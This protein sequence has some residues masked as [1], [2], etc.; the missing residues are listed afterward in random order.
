MCDGG[1]TEQTARIDLDPNDRRPA[2][3][4][5]KDDGSVRWPQTD[6]IW[7]DR[8]TGALGVIVRD[9][10][11]VTH[12]GWYPIDGLVESADF[13][14]LFGDGVPQDVRGCGQWMSSGDV[15]NEYRFIWKLTTMTERMRM[16]A[17]ANGYEVKDRGGLSHKVKAA[18]RTAQAVNE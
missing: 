13:E 1:E 17:R 8:T 18:F 11:V 14:V 3:W 12:I 2:W 10:M 7:A 4:S 5:R 6:Q 15:M 9:Q 16:W